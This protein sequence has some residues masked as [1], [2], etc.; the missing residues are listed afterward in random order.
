[1]K[2]GVKNCIM[3]SLVPALLQGFK[4]HIQD[5]SCALR[6]SVDIQSGNCFRFPPIRRALSS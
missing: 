2:L 3:F 1:M 5:N 4:K 6:V